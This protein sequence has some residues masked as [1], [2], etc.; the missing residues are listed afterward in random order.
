MCLIR[1][2][3]ALLNGRELER[4]AQRI[5]SGKEQVLLAQNA[6]PMAKVPQFPQRVSSQARESQRVRHE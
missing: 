5:S 1:Q 6:C 2:L 4:D 3:T